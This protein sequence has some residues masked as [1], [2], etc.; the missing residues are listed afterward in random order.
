[1][2]KIN[3][4]LWILKYVIAIVVVEV[5]FSELFLQLSTISRAH[6][7]S[8]CASDVLR[9]ARTSSKKRRHQNTTNAIT[10][11]T[12]SNSSSTATTT[13]TIA[14]ITITS[15]TISVEARV[16]QLTTGKISIV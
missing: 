3:C 4:A 11:S 12:T 1:M 16:E 6:V 13:I 10:T 7:K 14:T 2:F 15:A 8:A 5:V 9:K